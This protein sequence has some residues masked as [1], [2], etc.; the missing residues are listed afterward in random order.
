M[1]KKEKTV[2]AIL[3]VLL[4][5]SIFFF[6]LYKLFPYEI[7]SI[8]QKKNF[9]LQE[10]KVT[11]FKM[12]LYDLIQNSALIN[13]SLMLINESFPLPDDYEPALDEYKGI[14]INSS[15]K[16]SYIR[17]SG[18][19][20]DK[21][22]NPLYVMSAY[23]TPDEQLE[24]TESGNKYA[25]AVNSSEHLTGLALDVYVMYHAGRGFFDSPEGKYVNSYCQDYGFIIRYPDYGEEITGFDFEPWH[26][27][28]VGLP[29]SEIIAENKITLEEYILSFEPG[30]FYKYGGYIIS[31]QPE[32]DYILL[33]EGIS[34]TVI[35]P[36]NTGYYII[37]GKY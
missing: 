11:A 28:Y 35:S 20:K 8:F 31:R 14:Y 10:E 32:A 27:R 25:A 7:H 26:I 29:H 6:C 16:D 2:F 33:P 24:I 21:F 5:F 30:K 19:I 1:N 36:D 12:D 18:K 23:R 37:T 3:S 34:E 4:I 22:D 15:A 13:D 9:P 17:L